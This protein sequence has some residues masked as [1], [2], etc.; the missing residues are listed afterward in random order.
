MVCNPFYIFQWQRVLSPIS[1]SA[2]DLMISW[3]T[4]QDDGTILNTTAAVAF[5]WWRKEVILRVLRTR[6][7]N[8]NQQICL[9][10]CMCVCETERFVRKKKR[11]WE[12]LLWPQRKWGGAQVASAAKW[13]GYSKYWCIVSS[14]SCWHTKLGPGLSAC[15][16]KT[17]F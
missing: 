5:E 13:G 14:L 11:R 3:E 16:S 8:I 4:P 6:P 10:V 15:L 7:G 2:S 9:C 12:R 1:T 17:L